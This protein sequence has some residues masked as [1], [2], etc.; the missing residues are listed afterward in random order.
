M[1]VEEEIEIPSQYNA[2]TIISTKSKC[3][4]EPTTFKN[5]R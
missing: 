4:H 3:L 5:L 1:Q 2:K